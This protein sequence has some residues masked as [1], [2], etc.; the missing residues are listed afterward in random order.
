MVLG[1]RVQ[2][3]GLTAFGCRVLVFRVVEWRGSGFRASCFRVHFLWL[4]LFEFRV[5]GFAL[6]SGFLGLRG[7][8]LSI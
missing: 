2:V 1:L 6:G 8:R 5:L 4:S 3:V 7:S